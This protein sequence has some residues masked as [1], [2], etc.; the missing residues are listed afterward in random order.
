M[1]ESHFVIADKKFF[2]RFVG[3]LQSIMLAACALG[4]FVAWFAGDSRAQRVFG[5][6]CFALII[7]ASRW[8]LRF[9]PE[10]GVKVLAVGIWVVNSWFVCAFAGVHSA[11]V[12]VY[13]L[14]AAM[15]GWVLGRRWLV[16]LVAS[17]IALLVVIAFLELWGVLF[18]SAR[19]SP[20]VVSVTAVTVMICVAFLTRALSLDSMANR[21]QMGILSEKLREQNHQLI[22]QNRQLGQREREVLE[23]NQTL[24]L[25]VEKRTRELSNA[26][27]QLRNSQEGLA[28]S[29]RLAGLGALVAG[30]SHELNT[31]IGNSVTAA[32]TLVDIARDLH[33]H[34]AAQTLKRSQLNSE[35]DKFKD[36]A[37]LV[38]R[39]LLRAEQ[40]IQS[41]KQVAVDQT[42]EVRRKFFLSRV[43]AD[44]LESLAPSLRRQ[45]HTVTQSVDPLLEMDSFPGP[46]GQVIINL[47]QNAYTHAFPS[48]VITGAVHIAGEACLIEGR[49][50]GVLIRVSD[51]GCGITKENL[52][53]VF[54][55]FFTTRMGQGGTGLGL[56]LVYNIVRDVLGGDISVHSEVGLGTRFDIRLPLQAP[57]SSA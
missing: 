38:V 32:S 8:A 17:T 23:L 16:G 20:L 49:V 19:T 3:Q 18:P 54:E 33:A 50:P 12:V 26:M 55:P 44:V 57:S 39:N 43:V 9:G 27:L 15:C 35:L 47:V 1:V 21:Q 31:P 28:R 34:N 2:L 52:G 25:R 46:L 36:G 41:F 22:E 29:E 24:E 7:I 40:L 37:S 13:P 10:A 4:V 53:R 51:N 6:F 30:V 14:L 45:R 11:N 48:D 56:N 5:I 42:S